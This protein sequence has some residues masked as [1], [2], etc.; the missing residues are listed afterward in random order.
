VNKKKTPFGAALCASTLIAGV[1]PQGGLADVLSGALTSMAPNSWQ[2]LNLNQFQDVWTPKDLWPTL[3]S[4][5]SNISAWSGAAWDSRR[6][7]L[8]IWGGGIGDEQ[9]NEVY[10][11][12]ATT[13]LWERGAVPSQ[14]TQTG[15]ITHVVDGIN[16]APISGESWDN[17]VYLP[18]IDRMAV[19]GVS[20]EGL[21]FQNLDGSPTGP[22]F[23]DPAR[24]DPWKVS[25]TTGSHVN[26]TAYPNVVGGE[27]WQ[28][29]NNFAPEK[30]AAATGVTAHVSA[31]GKEV[32]YFAGR[33]DQLWRYTVTDLNPANDVWEQ[34][35][36][37]P[38]LGND[39]RGAA[40]IDPR[41]GLLVQTLGEQSFGFWDVNNTK[42]GWTKNREVEVFPAITEGT[43]PPN[44]ATFGL[45]FDPTLEAFLLWGGDQ[46]VWVLR[47]PDDLDPDGDGI[48]SQATGWTLSP[49]NPTG[50]GPTIPAK[51]TGVYGKWL[52]LA[53]ENAYVGVIDPYAGDVF[54]YKPPVNLPGGGGGGLSLTLG[55]SQIVGCK[56]VIGTVKLSAPAVTDRMVTITDTLPAASVPPSVT[57]PAGATYRSFT[58]ATSAVS[59]L[60]SGTVTA[61][62][63]G[64]STTQP[65]SLRPI[66]PKTMT[67]SPPSAVGG[68]LPAATAKLTLECRAGPGPI[69]VDLSTAKSE[70]A[71]PVADSVVVPVGTQSA[72][73]DV[74]TNQVYGKT[75][76]P[77]SAAANG[78]TVTKSLTVLPW[79]YVDPPTNLKFGGVVVGTTSNALNATLT[80]KGVGSFAVNS[81]SVTGTGASW[82]AQTNDCPVALAPGASCTIGVTFRPLSTTNRTAT[83]S[84]A[85]SATTVPLTVRL[86]GTGLPP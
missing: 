15:L 29:R 22:Y 81:I 45:Q 46:N 74:M 44:F 59:G 51:F 85:T 42:E 2:R 63:D 61:T 80:N 40:D 58:V 68:T 37:R 9:G 20:R 76:V 82:F 56:S 18:G 70:V 17:L 16:S 48:L 67:F 24:A 10:I 55:V 12:H 77:I 86:S 35:G 84:V 14:I 13:G 25:G 41:R 3:A 60:Q 7:D 8:L 11:F 26:P 30:S 47:P 83:L 57:I 28:N 53:Q 23:W 64:A 54:V 5:E 38:L 65:L 33:Y 69:T 21:T 31:E 72:V 43:P 62:L 39:G 50:A 19:I 32:V 75:L 73:F 49:L 1:L 79:A 52:Y 66:G 36:T 78:V 4:P 34:I 6:K 71:Y 27:M